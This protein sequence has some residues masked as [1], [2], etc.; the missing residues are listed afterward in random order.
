MEG[1][2]EKEREGGGE[3]KMTEAERCTMHFN[4]AV[5]V[6]VTCVVKYSPPAVVEH[7]PW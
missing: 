2:D 4:S 5:H 3:E 1:G 7:T 6:C